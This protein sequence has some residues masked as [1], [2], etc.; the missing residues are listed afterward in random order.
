MAEIKAVEIFFSLDESGNYEFIDNPENERR[1]K[2]AITLYAAKRVAAICS[3]CGEKQRKFNPHTMD[4]AKARLLIQIKLKNDA[5]VEWV[6]VQ[7]DGRLIKPSEAR[8]TI[9]CDD[10][11]ALRLKWFGLV[12]VQGFR[13]GKYRI[14]K[15][16]REFLAGT[17]MVPARILVKNGSVVWSAPEKILFGNIEGYLNKEFYDDYWKLQVERVPVAA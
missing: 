5:G 7:R 11:H 3:V 9:Q 10:V 8:G 12:E 17:F 2:K 4:L 14:N 1:M 6:K 13:T 15:N 16:G